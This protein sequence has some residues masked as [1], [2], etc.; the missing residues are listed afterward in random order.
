[1]KAKPVI[2]AVDPID[3]SELL[4]QVRSLLQVKAYNDLMSNY[5]KELESEVNRRTEKLTHAL[6]N[7][8]QDITAR[9]QAEKKLRE[10]EE[11]YKALFDRSL[12]LVYTMDFEG[13]F[14]D[15]N[16]A[17]LNRLGYTREEIPSLNFASLL[18]E[19]QLQPAIKILQEIRETGVQKDLSAFRLWHKDGTQVY[20]ETQ[21]S[22]V[23]SNGIPVA[24]QAIARDIT[25]RKQ[26]ER[27]LRESEERLRD[28][29]FNIADWV[30]EVDGNG[31]YTYSSQ[32]GLDVF[33]KSP[34]DIIGK[35][36]FDF[37]P[38]DEAKR[39]ATIFSEIVANK[40][41]IK[42][43][44]N[45]NIGRDGQRIC[46]LTNA[47]PIL[48][49]E[50]HLKGYRGVNKDITE[51]KQ[52]EKER[53]KLQS[54]LNQAQ[55]MEAVGRLAGG[56]A[57]DFNNMLAVILGYTEMAL[58]RVDPAQPLHADLEEILNAAR[59][60]AAIIRQLL[61]FAR[62]QTIDP[63][64]LDLN[65][66]VEGMLKMLRRLIGEDVDLI[67]RP[68]SGLWPIKM[69][70]TQVEQILANLC[71]NA[72]DAIAQVGK[73]TIETGNVAF[74]QAYCAD[75][76]GFVP[77]EYAMLA[78]S[79]DGRGMD[80]ES[81]N[82]MFEPFFTTKEMG[83]GTGLGLA[84]VYGIVK[85][86]NGFINIYSEP[87][88]GTTFKIYL[89]RQAVEDVEPQQESAAEIPRSR[90]ETVLVVE[91]EASLLKLAGEIL[92]NLGYTV[93]TAGTPDKALRLV[94]NFTGDI[95]LLMTD[96]ILPEMNG[97][98][99]AKQIKAIRPAMKCLFMSGYTAEVIAHRGMLDEGVQFI[100][101]PFS[102]RDLAAKV[103]TALEKSKR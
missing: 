2:L 98:D 85:Q 12:D 47:V 89:A 80:R 96:V 72:R 99:L 66:I 11:R 10:S 24:I 81:Q 53:E 55:K 25:D 95:H 13:R 63:K 78:I 22:S 36:P 21:G 5:P 100:P 48:D 83:Q 30:W 18:S 76:P 41:S 26:A 71:V 92:E 52:A 34:G 35:T 37:M 56:V 20:V 49:E 33:G 86:N 57:H 74:D 8:Q 39:V 103:R 6:E 79:D 45:W 19:D 7:L 42:D 75:H 44:E 101:K 67:W 88:E 93:L 97:R 40:A 3:K 31:V 77:G 27:K 54:Q 90:G 23:M 16:D 46:L 38:P 64:V 62:K 4:A 70:F 73:I 28:I 84:T 17:A 102:V 50:G 65:E 9:Q 61:A 43:L 14:I 51:R 59:G 15:A 29:I 82:K 69:D 94:G 91:D 32:K 58:G 68:A 60:S 1:M 87:G